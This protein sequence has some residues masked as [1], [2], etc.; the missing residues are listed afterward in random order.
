MSVLFSQV[1]SSTAD[2]KHVS[3]CIDLSMELFF[4]FLAMPISTA[5]YCTSFTCT[6][7]GDRRWMACPCQLGCTEDGVLCIIDYYC[8]VVNIGNAGF[9]SLFSILRHDNVITFLRVVEVYY[10]TFCYDNYLILFL[11]DSKNNPR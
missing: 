6:L 2:Q 7:F 3:V 9:D 11:A 10:L 5:Q 4:A 8:Q 1:C